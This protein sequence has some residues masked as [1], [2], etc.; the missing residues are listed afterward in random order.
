M[1]RIPLAILIGMLC[2]V[3]LSIFSQ[4]RAAA[5][6]AVIQQTPQQNNQIS[7]PSPGTQIGEPQ[8]SFTN[9]DGKIAIE[10]DGKTGQF[11]PGEVL[12]KFKFESDATEATLGHRTARGHLNTSNSRLN[13]IFGRFGVVDGKRLFAR[14]KLKF[15]SRIVKLSTDGNKRTREQMN[16]LLA[17]LRQQPEVEYAELNV[18]MHTQLVPNDA[19]YS[20]SSAWNQPFRDLG[21]CR[22]LAQRPPG[23]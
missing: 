2:F 9:Q 23:M 6:H 1:K 17:T 5:G 19:Y 15:L 4:N 22:Q 16:E 18:I 10:P 14:G 11:V 8:S 7:Q 3:A 20:T 12:V 13:N 21:A